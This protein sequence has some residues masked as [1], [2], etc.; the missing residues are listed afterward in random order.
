MKKM[1]Y[2]LPLAHGEDPSSVAAKLRSL[3][4]ELDLKDSFGTGDLIA[5]KTHFG[6]SSN[7]T[8]LHPLIVKAAVSEVKK[9][10]AHP[11]LTE[12]STLYRGKR[13]NAVEHMALAQEHGFGYEKMGAPLIMADGIFGESEILVN[14]EGKH[15]KQV[16]IAREIAKVQGLLALSHFKGHMVAGFGAAIKNIGMGLA[17]RKGKLKQHSLMSP[18]I[19]PSTCTAC[20]DCIEWCPQDTIEMAGGKARIRKEN[21]IGCGECLAV[22]RFGAVKFDFNRDSRSLQEMEVEHVAGVLKMVNENALF[23]NFL[24]N[25]TR[26]CD[27]MNGGD[28]VSKDIGIVAGRDIVAVDGA[29]ADL[30]EK[31]N[32]KSFQEAVY[33]RLDPRIQLQHAAAMG[34][35]SMEYELVELSPS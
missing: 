18:E 7:T 28:L 33:P 24:I 2:F 29:S 19:N 5:V 22:C 1:V 3:C 27:C 35:G 6:E 16:N 34:L 14:V 15:F 26:N 8:Y 21:C 9:T 13:S 30:F 11:F 23:I 4:R 25:I 12:T 32:G 20:G 10:G 31:K 17:S